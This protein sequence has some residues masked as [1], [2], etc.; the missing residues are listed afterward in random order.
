MTEDTLN[1]RRVRRRKKF[2]G[3]K[4]VVRF[5]YGVVA[6]VPLLLEKRRSCHTNQTGT[7]E[8]CDRFRVDLL[9]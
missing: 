2:D 9:D 1:G 3:P 5:V 8:G 4:G 6:E 7:I